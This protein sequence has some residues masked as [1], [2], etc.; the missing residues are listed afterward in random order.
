MINTALLST[1]MAIDALGQALSGLFVVFDDVHS[2]KL[3]ERAH[4]R[5]LTGMFEEKKGSVAVLVPLL[6]THMTAI[7]QVPTE[8]KVAFS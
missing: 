6:T 7:D 1:R 5:V 3:V 8:G 4:R 2:S